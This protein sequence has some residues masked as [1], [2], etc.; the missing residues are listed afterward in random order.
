M[1]CVKEQ[2]SIIA[3]DFSKTR[4]KK[5][6]CVNNFLSNIVKTD[7]ILELGC[8][9]GKN[10]YDIKEQS[11]GVDICPE[12]C[13]ICRDKGIAVIESNVLDVDFPEESFDYIL[14]IAVIHHIK[15]E[16]D[17]IKLLNIINKILKTNGKALITGWT[18]QEPTRNLVHGDNIVKFGKNERYYYIFQQYELYNLCKQ[19]FN[20]T[21]Y[22]FECYND[23]I[24]VTKPRFI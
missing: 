21:D 14:C 13:K 24:V 16:D 23:V 17:K 11:I 4:Y 18:T 22:S 19:V 8:G 10:I 3:S 12:F 1:L 2:Y 7:S 5:W 9:N 15:E 20:N 6:N